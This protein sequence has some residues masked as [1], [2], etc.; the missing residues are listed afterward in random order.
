[1]DGEADEGNQVRQDPLAVCAFD[2][3]FLQRR[4]GLPEL[5]FVPEV[6][7]LFDG[8]GQFL[9]VLEGEA[10]LIGLTVARLSL[11]DHVHEPTS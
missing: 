4:V 11:F 8:V 1:M 3:R 6:R 10:L 5:G 7:R 2:L 9:D